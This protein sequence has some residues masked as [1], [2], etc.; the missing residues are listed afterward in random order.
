MVVTT[1]SILLATSTQLQKYIIFVSVA[2]FQSQSRLLKMAA[3][4]MTVE[5]GTIIL[6]WR[7]ILKLVCAVLWT[8]TKIN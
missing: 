4:V 7:K 5:F 6:V 1:C 8:D 2:I 3:T